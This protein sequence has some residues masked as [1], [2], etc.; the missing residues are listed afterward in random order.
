[1]NAEEVTQEMV[2]IQVRHGC[3]KVGGLRWSLSWCNGE[4]KYLRDER[5]S[6]K[7]LTCSLARAEQ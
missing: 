3:K 5:L 4:M 1:M 6:C 2:A 7:A